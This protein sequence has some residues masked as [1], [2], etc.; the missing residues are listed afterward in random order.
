MFCQLWASYRIFSSLFKP[1][2]TISRFSIPEKLPLSSIL[3]YM[4]HL[5]SHFNPPASSAME[6]TNPSVPNVNVVSPVTPSVLPS[7]SSV[8]F[9]SSPLKEKNGSLL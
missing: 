3:F 6:L 1:C 8:S 7:A 5:F 4:K 2:K 9:L